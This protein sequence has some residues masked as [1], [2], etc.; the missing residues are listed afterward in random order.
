MIT[1]VLSFFGLG[2]LGLRSPSGTRSSAYWASW[3]DAL[4]EM[5]T[6]SPRAAAAIL[7]VMTD[8]RQ[9]TAACLA[10]LRHCQ[11][12]LSVRG[13]EIAEW[14]DIWTGQRPQQP[15]GTEPGEWKHGWQYVAASQKQKRF[16]ATEVE[17]SMSE[18]ELALLKS[19]SGPCSGRHLELLPVTNDSRFSCERLR[20]L[21]MRRLRLPLQCAAHRCNGRSCRAS[22]DVCGDHRGAC[23]RAGRL[24]KRGSPVE[25]MWARVCREGSKGAGERFSEGHEHQWHQCH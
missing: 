13:I 5:R 22:L 24:V 14:H 18:S 21:L 11:S 19:Q 3:A 1:S 17:P 20:A 10:E 8:T 16:M 12:W 2:G 15:S 25:R 23:S 9:P 4:P 7:N 6:R